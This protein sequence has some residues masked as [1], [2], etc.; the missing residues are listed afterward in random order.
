MTLN[1]WLQIVA[2][3][4]ILLA[5]VKPLGV[6]MARVYEGMPLALDRLLGPVECW[7]YRLSGVRPQSA[8]C[9]YIHGQ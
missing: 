4:V 3:L 9:L 2:F 6:Y 1:G 8:L 5:A 7:A